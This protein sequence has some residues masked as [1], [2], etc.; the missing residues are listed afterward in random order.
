MKNFRS[1]HAREKR[2]EFD[3]T[4]FAV[5]GFLVPFI[6]SVLVA[7]DQVQPQPR[8]KREGHE[9]SEKQSNLPRDL[10]SKCHSEYPNL[11]VTRDV[12]YYHA[13]QWFCVAPSH[14][15]SAPSIISLKIKRRERKK[16]HKQKKTRV[17]ILWSAIDDRIYIRKPKN[18]KNLFSTLSIKTSQNSHWKLSSYVWE[19]P[20]TL[21]TESFTQWDTR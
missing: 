11:E 12:V 13:K 2:N 6:S 18:L 21:S 5:E 9:G 15:S 16:I 10:Y 1:L 7:V 17:K 20:N 8:R 14:H 19:P 3:E 4:E